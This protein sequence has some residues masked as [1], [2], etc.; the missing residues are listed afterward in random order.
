MNASRWR[1]VKMLNK[2]AFKLSLVG[3][4]WLPQLLLHSHI[5][6]I[7][8]KLIIRLGCQGNTLSPPPPLRCVFFRGINTPYDL[9]TVVLDCS[10]YSTTMSQLT[11]G[12]FKCKYWKG[13][14]IR[15]LMHNSAFFFLAVIIGLGHSF[16]LD[17]FFSFSPSLFSF[18]I[19]LSF[20]CEKSVVIKHFLQAFHRLCIALKYCPQL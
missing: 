17:F 4:A 3:L 19:R 5:F 16:S 2:A 8:K 6:W 20:D 12:F 9:N 18:L 11:F 14:L 7:E 1:F 10:F 13:F 15:Y